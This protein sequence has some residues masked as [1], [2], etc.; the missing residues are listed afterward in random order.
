[1]MQTT[2]AEFLIFI[3]KFILVKI[4]MFFIKK[5]AGLIS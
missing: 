1:M 3:F 2:V 4:V 5:P